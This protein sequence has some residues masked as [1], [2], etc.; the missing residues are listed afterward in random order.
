MPTYRGMLSTLHAALRTVPAR[1]IRFNHERIHASPHYRGVP[2]VHEGAY[3]YDFE[4]YLIFPDGGAKDAELR[5][6]LLFL[7]MRQNLPL[8]FSD[9]EGFRH[10]ASKAVPLWHPPSRRTMTRR[11]EDKY[12]VLSTLVRDTMAQL[13]SVCLTADCWT[14]THTTNSFLGVTVHFVVETSMKTACIGLLKLEESHTGM[15]LSEKL[16]EFCDNWTIDPLKVEAVVV[17]NAENIKL[18]VKTAFGEN[19]LINCFDHTLNLV[20]KYALGPKSDKDP[21]PWVVGVPS[22]VDKVKHIVTYSHQST[23]FSNELKRIQVEQFGK[24]EGT[25]LR[26]SQEV[27]TRWGSAY[28][29]M[30]RFLELER[31]VQLAVMSFPEV[32]MLTAAE[33]ATLRRVMGVLKPFHDATTEMGAEKTTTISK[34]IPL[35]HIICKVRA[36][37]FTAT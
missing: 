15:Y 17:D 27:R 26:L 25:M 8:S 9:G 6:A 3:V 33:L 1:S 2:T 37:Y 24:T 11:M 34:I 19:K 22:L 29:M 7:E 12:Q 18:A 28:D 4:V 30:S 31:V 36:M 16:L 5:D 32:N 35:S 10:F 21:T 20:P 23:N 13:D 14:E